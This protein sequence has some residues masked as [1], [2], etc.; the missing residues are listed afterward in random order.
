MQKKPIML[1]ILDG[2]GY[3][4]T[5]KYNAIAQAHTPHMD[6]W[7]ATYPH[8][9][10][11]AS[12]TAVGLLPGTIGNSEV[13]HLTIGSGRIIQ[14]PATRLHNAIADKSFFTN[15]V[16]TDALAKI[17]A[18]Q[19][20]LHI[21]GLLSDAGVHSQEE[22]LFAFLEAACQHNIAKIVVHPFVDG[23]DVPP[24]SAATYLQRLDTKLKE[25]GHGV[26]GSIHGRFYAM[27]R[28]HNWDRTVQSYRAL[29]QPIDEPKE[30]TTWQ[31]VLDYYYA[32]NITDEFIPPTQLKPRHIIHDNDGIIFFNFR[33]DRARQLTASF[34]QK[35]FDHFSTIPLELSCFVTP[36]SY[37]DN[38]HTSVLLSPIAI[39]HTLK[40]VLVAHHKTIF[41]IA[42]TEKYAHITYF[43]NGHKEKKLP[44]E[45]RILIP[46][47]RAKNYVQ[48]PCMSA[49]EITQTVL[50]SL[51]TDPAD[52]YL[53]NYANADMVGHSGNLAATIKAI[54]C[55]DQ[56][57]KKLYDNIITQLD[58][59]MFIT[60]DHGNAEDMY[61]EKHK[62][63]RTAHTTN[64]VPFIMITSNIKKG[65][66]HLPLTQLADIAPFILR[67]MHLPIP[68]EMTD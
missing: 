6:K 40:D 32:Q 47:I 2:F 12:G 52:F 19:G 61:D 49:V 48:Y 65:E 16:L 13:G 17:H 42:E 67:Y 46:S 29:T 54:E 68:P 58:G 35:D 45:T 5:I 39:H 4:S 43:F 30:F 28:D 14:Q 23:R 10:L 25:L 55:L 62:Q 64:P 1:I 7:L 38:L 41:S 24:R 56:E 34:V 9:L 63:P 59:T 26:I 21:M 37:A 18:K 27:D 44:G 31:E 50:E 53:I 33:E 20:T 22:D 60:A 11:R 57:L 8:T 51:A 36:I 15:K 66:K 3:S